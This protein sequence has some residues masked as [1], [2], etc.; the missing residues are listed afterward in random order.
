MRKYEQKIELIS[1]FRN[2]MEN[3]KQ[4]NN[5]VAFFH[6]DLYDDCKL[7]T[8]K[9]DE[10]LKSLLDSFNQDNQLELISSYLNEISQDDQIYSQMKSKLNTCWE[11]IKNENNFPVNIIED[12]FKDENIISQNEVSITEQV[13]DNTK[14]KITKICLSLQNDINSI[15]KVFYSEF[16]NIAN[17]LS[18]IQKNNI[19][20][21]KEKKQI[22]NNI[23]K[24]FIPDISIFN[25]YVSINLQQMFYKT[26]K[27]EIDK[28]SLAETQENVPQPIIKPPNME[29]PSFIQSL[30]NTSSFNPLFQHNNTSLFN[31]FS[32]N[33]FPQNSL[34]NSINSTF[35]KQNRLNV[36]NPISQPFNSTENNNNFADFKME[37]GNLKMDMDNLKRMIEQLQAENKSLKEK[38]QFLE[39][40]LSANEMI[41]NELAEGNEEMQDEI[42][43]LKSNENFSNQI[44]ILKEKNSE[45]QSE[46]DTLRALL[47]S[48]E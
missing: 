14:D 40:K 41:I 7:L 34:R 42:N 21:S 38:N 22:F 35:F 13:I 9:V 31:D 20:N 1:T 39:E 15:D 46:N 37:N 4:W 23:L 10:T 24:Y 48:F 25:L 47:E 43:R 26:F 8:K 44:D 2:N 27:N 36:R 18:S 19:D 28:I 3:I 29:N 32:I 11:K 33:H 17:D 5:E 6:Q 30:D 45:L 12:I 16:H